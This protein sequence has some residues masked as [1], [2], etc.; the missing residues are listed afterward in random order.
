MNISKKLR[1]EMKLMC[2]RERHGPASMWCCLKR[3][4]DIEAKDLPV[5]SA[6]S[7]S[8]PV[9]TTGTSTL[10][11]AC[12]SQLIS[13]PLSSSSPRPS[14]EHPRHPS[15]LSS[16]VPRGCATDGGRV[17][18]VRGPLQ[19]V[20]HCCRKRKAGCFVALCLLGTLHSP[21]ELLFNLLVTF[22][23]WFLWASTCDYIWKPLTSWSPFT[24]L[25]VAETVPSGPWNSLSIVEDTWLWSEGQEWGS[26]VTSPPQP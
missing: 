21:L 20:W 12:S 7:S 25:S 22:R 19:T 11:G 3:E 6:G 24:M 17:R 16:A 26:A 18:P 8:G 15:S 2:R 9:L 23:G 10:R 13:L 4:T 14:P 1:K 5:R